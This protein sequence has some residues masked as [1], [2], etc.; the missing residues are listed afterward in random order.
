M[1]VRP[2]TL[3]SEAETWLSALKTT[4]NFRSS[5][6]R[7]SLERLSKGGR[8]QDLSRH[9]NLQLTGVLA[10]LRVTGDRELLEKVYVVMQRERG[11]LR[12]TDGDGYLN[13]RYLPA[14]PTK[15]PELSGTDYHVMEEIMAH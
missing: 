3:S 8:V 10:A 12:D 9:L 15:N 5:T 6:S 1:R 11:T 2:V 13:W 7:Y 14:R 4:E